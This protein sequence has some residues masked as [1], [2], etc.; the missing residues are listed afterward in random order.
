MSHRLLF[1]LG[2]SRAKL[3][4]S[5]AQG[6]KPLLAC[7]YDALDFDA[8]IERALALPAAPAEIWFSDVARPEVGDALVARC[9][10]H[11]PAVRVERPRTPREACGVRSAY[12][13][14]ERLGI[15]RFFA[16]LAAQQAQ[17]QAQLIVHVGTALVLD[18]LAPDGQHLGG[19]ILPAPMLMQQSLLQR[20]ARIDLG[21]E[22]RIVDFGTNTE[23]AVASGC[24]RAAAVLVED[25][26]ARLAARTG[27]VPALWLTGGGAETLAPMLSLQCRIEAM[28][29]LQ[30]LDLYA[31][32]R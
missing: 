20:T 15:D 17:A 5:S 13:E 29:V 31:G 24:W 2:N 16:M 22:G 4:R 30:G 6:L 10:L 8:Q 12:R 18:A 3:A 21:R 9:R 1:D 7:A 11:F 32:T 14:S 25:T 23:D 19:L 26:W 28:L 27:A